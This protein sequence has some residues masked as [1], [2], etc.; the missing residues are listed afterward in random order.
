MAEEKAKKQIKT[1]KTAV[2]KVTAKKEK[3]VTKGAKKMAT[4][5]IAPTNMHNG[6]LNVRA[7]LVGTRTERKEAKPIETDTSKT[8][9]PKNA[10][11]DSVQLTVDVYDI[12][13]KI[14]GKVSLPVEIFGEKVNKILLAQAVRVHLANKRQGT[15]STKTRGEVDGSTRKIYRQKGTGRARHGSIRAP[16]FVKGGVVFGPKPRDFSLGFPKKMKRKALFSALS[17]KLIDNEIQV[18][19]GFS[20]I[21]PKTKLFV[22]V[23]RKAGLEGK[24]RKLLLVLPAGF[25]NLKRAARNVE[26]VT[27]LAA[28]QLNAYEVLNT[29]KLLLMK[30]AIAE[31]EKQYLK[32]GMPNAK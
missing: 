9:K 4:T 11:K 19:S 21:E 24:K 32:N 1:K 2:K 12:E 16:I 22:E 14:S 18:M 26:G 25:D 31:M 3:P 29:R 28:N 20:A 27:L 10:A 7:P 23:L 5:R 13:G 6:D 17:A 8:V 15:V 30:E